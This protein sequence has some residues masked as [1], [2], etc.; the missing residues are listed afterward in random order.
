[1]DTLSKVFC[2]GFCLNNLLLMFVRT[3]V[4]M[5]DMKCKKINC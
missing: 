1:M 3:S 2:P 4:V 5:L